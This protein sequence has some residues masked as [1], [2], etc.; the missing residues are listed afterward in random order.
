LDA[1]VFRRLP[2]DDPYRW[3]NQYLAEEKELFDGMDRDARRMVAVLNDAVQAFRADTGDYPHGLEE[4]LERPRRLAG[5]TGRWPYFD[6]P[7]I[8]LDPWRQPYRYRVPGEVNPQGFDVYSVHG[9]SRNPP[10]WVGNW[11]KPYRLASAIEGETLKP[12]RASSDVTARAQEITSY[13]NAPISNGGWLFL[14]LDRVGAW[15]E[16]ELPAGIQA[17]RYRVYLLAGTS[18]DYG[19]VRWSLGGQPLGGPFDGLTPEIGRTVLPA[20]TVDLG[21]GSRVLRVE[22]VGRNDRSQ[23]HYAA[24]DAILLEPLPG[25]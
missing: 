24:L 6:A 5:A 15:A 3:L 1:I 18:W 2:I 14:R 13:G 4:L 17:G 20:A 7:R 22:A 8:P 19:I 23:R 11:T 12:A 16:F 9:R 10:Y 21:E 25:E